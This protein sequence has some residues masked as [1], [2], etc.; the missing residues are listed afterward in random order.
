[1]KVNIEVDCTP[2]EARRF[3][4]LPDVAPMQQAVMEAMEQRLVDAIAST[5]TAEADGAMAAAGHQGHGAVAGAVDADRPVGGGLPRSGGKKE[6]GVSGRGGG[7]TIYAPATPTGRSA[8]GVMRITGPAGG[9]SGRA[10]TGRARLRRGEPLCGGC[11]T[12]T[13]RPLDEALL[14][15]LPAPRSET[16][17][18]VLEIQHHGGPAVLAWLLEVLGRLAWVPAGRPRRVHRRAFLN[19]KL[20]LT[21]AEGWPT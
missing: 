17:E 8:L 5:D 10:L 20:D 1:M 12:R 2:D 3:L 11:A 7:G 15:W 6:D 14:L 13:G 19:G 21:A 4:G 18:D 9:R 16:G